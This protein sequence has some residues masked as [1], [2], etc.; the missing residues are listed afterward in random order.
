MDQEILPGVGN[1]I[2]NEA[3]FDAGEEN[4]IWCLVSKGTES[5]D[6]FYLDFLTCKKFLKL[7][8]AFNV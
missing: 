3:C 2:K 6:Y 4:K 8:L 1:I 7:K 5:R